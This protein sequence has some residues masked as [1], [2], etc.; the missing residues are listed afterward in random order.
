MLDCLAWYNS[1]TSEDSIFK[2]TLE[3][4]R[5]QI[6]QMAQAGGY[7]VIIE[8]GCHLGTIIG[9]LQTPDSIPRYGLESKS[10]SAWIQFCQ[11]HYHHNNIN[12]SSFQVLENL[13]QLVSWWQALQ[14]N[15][16]YK[17][18]KPLVFCVN[19]A[20][21][22]LD[23]TIRGTVVQQML[24]V[25]GPRGLGLIGYWNGNF[26]SH[27]ALNYYKRNQPLFGPFDMSKVNQGSRIMVTIKTNT[28]IDT[29]AN[30]DTTNIAN[31]QKKQDHGGGIEFESEW[32]LPVQAQQQLRAYDIDVA[33]PQ[34]FEGLG[35]VPNTF[36]QII[37]DAE[38]GNGCGSGYG[39][40]GSGL[41][42]LIWFDESCT[43]RA[44]LYY[45][46]DDA[47][48][49]YKIMGGGGSSGHQGEIILHLGRH[50]LLSAQ[51]KAQLSVAQQLT[52]AQDLHEHDFCQTLKRKM[53]RIMESKVSSTLSHPPTRYRIVEFGCGY[54]GLLR[55]LYRE[56]VIWTGIGC[57]I[58]NQMCQQARL[59]NQQ[60]GIDTDTVQIVEESFLQL[61]AMDESVDFVVSMDSLLH[62]G[63]DR[64][65]S[66][67]QEA[68]RILRPG[69]WLV[70]TDICERENMGLQEMLPIYDRIHLT[71]MGT[72]SNYVDAMKECGFTS[73]EATPYSSSD[74]SNHYGSI[75]Q[76][77]LEQKDSLGV[78]KEYFEKTEQGLRRW[79]DGAKDKLVWSL[80]CGQK[81]RKVDLAKLRPAP[82]QY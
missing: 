41:A 49:F 37:C 13:L 56:G 22:S 75:H 81:T 42:I 35:F 57:D 8:V 5:S 67:I 46:S 47:Q 33:M 17:F 71:E 80:F 69:G 36:P 43:S 3:I 28:N 76:V 77:L 23:K 29:T 51:D 9:E 30:T 20:L 61:S 64:Q 34:P 14:A 82:Y 16:E 1:L 50:D 74:V 12:C 11:D 32:Y 48:T 26:F 54:G 40:N 66:S 7:D 55:R 65:R 52:K 18:Q 10:N 4:T 39:N 62:V 72:V 73:V 15:N 79:R 38:F 68:A 63:P 25:A 59:L 2:E 78:S 58:S 31:L 70:F 45:D 19:N 44:K 27:A 6:E 53:K 60:Q 21:A 24:T